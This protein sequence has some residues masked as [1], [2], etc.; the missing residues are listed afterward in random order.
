MH[1]I[2]TRN[3]LRETTI[4]IG[5]RDTEAIVLHFAAH[6]KVLTSQSLLHAVVPV[7]YVLFAIGIGQRQ[8]GIFVSH[9]PELRLQVATHAL[10]W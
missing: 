7:A 10:R 5:E 2:T 3:S 1:T 9:L 4:N 8:H 6:L